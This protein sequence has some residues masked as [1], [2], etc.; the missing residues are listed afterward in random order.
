MSRRPIASVAAAALA[1]L[2]VSLVI[3]VPAGGVTT[4]VGTQAPAKGSAKLYLPDT[5]FVNGNA[6]TLPRRLVTVR[7]VV[8]PFVAGQW[9][10]VRAFVNGRLFK[11]DKLR[12][13]RSRNGAFGRFAE[14]VH[15]PGIGHV[16]VVVRHDR[17]ST[18]EGFAT[19]RSFAA[20]DK[21][22][23]FGSTGRF[24]QLIQRRL[25]AL[26]FYIPQTG[27]YDG[28]TGL[29]IDA[30]HRLLGW[31]TYQTLDGATISW[32]LDGIG[33]FKVRYPG[34]GKHAEGNLG[35]QLLALING[36]HVYWILPF[37][38]GKPSTPTVTGNFQV[39]RRVAG[40]QPDGM[41]FSSYFYTGYAI[42]GYDPAPD[43]PASHGCLR[44]PIADAIDV[45]NWLDFGNDVDVYY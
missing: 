31:G 21:N 34:Q 12:I 39:Y 35:N 17:T 11:T 44:L 25:S 42:H 29:A 43:Y 6:V 41:Y 9:V 13:K 10:T 5:F 38:S 14:I 26:H 19:R 24:V 7:G 32:L 1:P 37:S 18:Q 30:Y 8:R 27:V 2:A 36:S 22:V 23:G 15:S 4:K 3:A 28:G 45:Y 16:V 33:S 40:Y 20:L